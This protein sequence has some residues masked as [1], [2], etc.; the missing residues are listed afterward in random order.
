MTHLRKRP[1]VVEPR[2]LRR[3]RRRGL[4]G[5]IVGGHGRLADI[6]RA[7]E[8][9]LVGRGVD[10]NSRNGGGGSH[11]A[12]VGLELE[13]RRR[14]EV[15]VGAIRHLAHRP[16]RRRVETLKGRIRGHG[17]AR[18]ERRPHQRRVGIVRRAWPGLGL[19]CLCCGRVVSIGMPQGPQQTAHTLLLRLRRRL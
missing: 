17:R 11:L 15:V 13:R 19:G 10:R 9:W 8:L 18:R 6:R 3:R 5:R 2:H 7:G 4:H 12:R 16:R 1:L 14:L